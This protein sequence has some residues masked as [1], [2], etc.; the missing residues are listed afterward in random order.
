MAKSLCVFL[1]VCIVFATVNAACSEHHTCRRGPRGRDGVDGLNG[2]P[3]RPG[4][5]GPPGPPGATGPPGPTGPPGSGS[6]I[7]FASLTTVALF[8]GGVEPTTAAVTAFGSA[9][10]GLNLIGG[11]INISQNDQSLI[12]NTAFVMPRDGLLTSITSEFTTASPFNFGSN[13]VTIT[14]QLFV[15]TSTP[16]VFKA[17][18]DT[19]VEL[20]P[21]LTGLTPANSQFSGSTTGITVSL[22]HRTRYI[23]V[24]R[25]VSGDGTGHF[26]VGYI[27]GG[28][29]IT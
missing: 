9:A 8:D 27:S 16:N 23:F 28:I 18:P 22:A 1:Y 26:V 10:D 4:P 13:V 29:N 7:L 14:S 21:P 19:H 2:R 15:Q 25:I 11:L 5:P 3:G 17:I 6:I 24:T 12:A 20:S